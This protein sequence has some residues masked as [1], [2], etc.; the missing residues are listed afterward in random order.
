MY[1][2]SE[3]GINCPVHGDCENAIL[4]CFSRSCKSYRIFCESCNRNEHPSSC[5]PDHY[6]F[7]KIIS[8]FQEIEK[9]CESLEQDLKLTAGEIRKLF[10]QIIQI[11][12]K[13]YQYSKQRLEELNSKQLHQALD[14]VIKYDEFENNYFQDIKKISKNLIKE[15]QTL[16]T[17]LKLE[18][19]VGTKVL[20]PKAKLEYFYQKG[21]E[22]LILE[23]NHSMKM[24][25]M[26]KQLNN[27][28]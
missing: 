20:D 4:V 23:V 16:L 5:R 27:Q 28:T 15:L 8:K 21:Y 1:Q 26:N 11:I 10:D 7:E 19:E 3:L 14:N 12:T 18:E 9:Q 24:I 22:L 6:K 2:K 13:K 25:I 17:E